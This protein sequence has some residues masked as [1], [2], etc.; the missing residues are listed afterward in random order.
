MGAH[1][2]SAWEFSSLEP[3]TSASASSFSSSSSLVSTER[4]D[5]K[6]PQQEL[7][8]TSTNNKKK[9]FLFCTV[10]L[11]L[12][13][14]IP[15]YIL[16]CCY[17]YFI[18]RIP[19]TAVVTSTTASTAMLSSFLFWLSFA[20]CFLYATYDNN[21]NNNN[22]NNNTSGNSNSSSST[23]TTNYYHWLIGILFITI[24]FRAWCNLV[25]LTNDDNDRY[26][27]N[28]GS[29]SSSSSSLLLSRTDITSLS[30]I[31]AIEALSSSF[32]STLSILLIV[33]N[34]D[35]GALI[36]GRIFGSIRKRNAS[37][38]A[39]ATTTTVPE[40]IRRISPSKTMEGFVGGIIGGTVT[41]IWGVPYLLSV[42]SIIDCNNTNY[43]AANID[44]NGSD[45]ESISVV[46]YDD[47]YCQLWGLSSSSSSYYQNQN[48]LWIGL[49]LSLLAI[50]GD[51]IESSIKR[52]SKSKDSGTVLP[53]HGGILD[54]FDSSLL[55]I[56]FY[57]FLLDYYYSYNLQQ[58]QQQQSSIE[59]A[60]NNNGPYTF[61]L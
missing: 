26:G 43:T 30:S 50:I 28:N 49:I 2:L 6:Q 51:L 56:L 53:G 15:E 46:S 19:T 5:Q 42:V 32:A 37:L 20:G 3:T 10:S 47:A 58:Q 45:D 18:I 60:L 39:T 22:N 38:N 27:N 24:P 57:R 23:T 1:A 34:T 59:A 8:N 29:T 9:R 16:H 12:A 55:A 31:A 36:V 4:H 14:T 21:N 41:S 44:S 35:T 25:T 13:S 48:R 52:K 7:T 54:R 33:W 61:E 11:L 17:D 40:W